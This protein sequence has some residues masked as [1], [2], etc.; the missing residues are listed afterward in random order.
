MS[1]RAAESTGKKPAQSRKQP[2]L[3]LIMADDL[4]YGH[5][6]R[7]GQKLI[8]TPNI[9][10]LAAAGMRFT[11]F[12]AGAPVCA[13]SRCVLMT[14]LHGGHTSVR[15]NSGGIAIR[16]EDVTV[17]EVLKRAGYTTAIIGKWGLGEHG[18]VGVPYHQ[19][20]DQFFGYLHQIHAHFYYPEYLWQ[21]DKKFPLA[22][23]A[24]GRREQYT[25]DECL[26]QTLN[27]VRGHREQPF[28]LYVPFAVPHYELLVPE[29]SLKEYR[30]QFAET[31]YTGRG[32]KAGYPNDYAAQE[33]PRAALAA[34]VTRMDRN[35]GR[36]LA[37]LKEL[38]L[39]ENTIVLFTSD[40]GPSTGPADPDFFH[41]AGPS[42]GNKS[43]LYEGGIRVPLI[44]SWPNHIQPGS[45][46][47][48]AGYFADILPTLAELGGVRAPNGLDGLSIVPAL[49]GEMKAGRAQAEHEFLYW[50]H[51]DAAMR[52]VRMGRWKGVRPGKHSPIELYD[53][54]A[55]ER[56]QHDAAA[57]NPQIVARILAI[58]SSAHVDAPPQIEPQPPAGAQYQ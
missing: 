53:L 11:Q 35:V 21:N 39:D 58:L 8:R 16:D 45:T 6:G 15:G 36:I 23:N 19:G 9:D 32:R 3:V 18:T 4:G 7:Y 29:D 50:E 40:N 5:L 2:N 46:N 43:T 12:Y 34:M 38:Q 52:A 28:F 17:A 26:E 31:P 25:E 47:E 55:D 33:T 56:E 41:A 57:A 13:S 10:R 49:L 37:L 1:V 51:D 44:A 30:G 20:F 27:F 14:G 42:R 54:S 48:Y 24:N 22:K